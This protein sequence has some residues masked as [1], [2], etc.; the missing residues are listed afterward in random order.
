[1]HFGWTDMHALSVCHSRSVQFTEILTLSIEE[2]MSDMDFINFYNSLS[3]SF[4]LMVMTFERIMEM[5]SKRSFS[6]LLLWIWMSATGK[7]GSC[8]E[9]FSYQ[10]IWACLCWNPLCIWINFPNTKR[11]SIWA[12][13]SSCG[14]WITLRTLFP[15]L[16]LFLFLFEPEN[17]YSEQMFDF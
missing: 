1:M 2:I 3:D 4:T 5:V 9:R 13:W 6:I 8:L 16:V 15:C 7:C 11:A 14:Y 12:E 10:N 17:T